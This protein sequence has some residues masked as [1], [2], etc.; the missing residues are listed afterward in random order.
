MK[1]VLQQDIKG[2]GKKDEL[3]N[4]S[5]GY[6]RNY[7]IPRG[8][9]IVADSAAMSKIK[10]KNEALE[11]RKAVELDNAKQIAAVINGNSVKIEAK[12]GSAGR[13]FG[14]ITSKEVSTALKEQYD[15]DLDKRKIDLDN[16]I[17]TFGTY[18]AKAKIYTGVNADFYVIVTEKKS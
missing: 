10:S 12:A 6:A 16:D 1:V 9:A 18:N 14:S 17:K 15:V 5:D 8:L 11:H 3:V 4:V 2:T 7:L 13:L